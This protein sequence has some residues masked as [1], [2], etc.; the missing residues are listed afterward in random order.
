MKK[1]R[2]NI[3][4]GTAAFVAATLLVS[5][6]ANAQAPGIAMQHS[7]GGSATDRAT[8]AAATSDGGYIMTGYTSSN[9]TGDVSSNHGGTDAW[10]AKIS[11]TGSLTWQTSL[12]SNINE[13]GNSIVETS[14][15]GYVLAGYTTAMANGDVIGGHGSND[16][17]VV[18][19][20]STGTISWAK[21]L[22]GTGVENAYSIKETFD[23]GFIA[24]GF[25]SSTSGE[26][27]GN[28][29]GTD[30]WIVKLTSTGAIAWQRS[31]GGASSDYAYSVVQ[32]TDTGFFI[33]GNSSSSD[34]DLSV[35]HGSSDIWAIKL[36]K[37]GA[38]QWSK[39]IGGSNSEFGY[40]CIQLT[41]GNYAVAGASYSNDGDIT[42]AKGSGDFF[43]VKL[44]QTGTIIWNKNYGG[45]G[46]E[47]ARGIQATAAGGMIVA[48]YSASNDVDVTGNHGTT[49]S[50][51]VKLSATG[52]LQWQKSYGGTDVDETFGIAKTADGG[53]FLASSSY[54]NDGDA[55]ANNG[56]MDFWAVK[57]DACTPPSPTITVSGT[58]LGTSATYDTYQ[59]LLSG[60]PIVGA[61]GATYVATASG[62]YKVAVTNSYD[63]PATSAVLPF[64]MPATGI[65]NKYPASTDV[66]VFPN[67]ASLAF[68]ILLPETVNVVQVS[69]IDMLGKTLVARIVEQTESR[70]I[71]IGTNGMPAGNYL[72]KITDGDKIYRQKLMLIK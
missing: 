69:L 35:N 28:H 4:I 40:A 51:V 71:R 13:A 22:G 8:A 58:T 42:S 39:S 11:A 64:T 17:W 9:M 53:W 2:Y 60:T 27:T 62:D 29:G 18:K 34:A 45:T 68:T 54:S 59:W 55:T 43:V 3:V 41:D 46:D 38:T 25:S 63:C 49:D 15:G 32:T 67:P 61:T 16:W 65:L 12:G 36:D 20:T 50:W 5:V 57:L 10:V 47:E 44:S 52:T 33:A 56:S 48:G 72:I 19:L 23:G 30:A 37:F 70:D 1:K 7:F 26:V 31:M 66:A 6:G 24:V 21:C 14:D